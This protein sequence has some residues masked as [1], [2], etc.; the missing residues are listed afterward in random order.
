MRNRIKKILKEE[1]EWDWARESEP[2]SKSEI[3]NKLLRFGDFGFSIY[4]VETNDLVNSIYNLGL[5]TTQLD[6][7][8]KSLYGFGYNIYERGMDA[9]GE[10]AWSEG[11]R[12]G[13][14]EGWSEAKIECENDADYKYDKGHE[15]GYDKGYEEGESEGYVEGYK[16]GY[17]EGSEE[18]YYKAFEE[19]R[20]YEAGV[21]VEDLERIESGFDPRDYDEEYDENY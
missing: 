20:A 9:G 19:G 12:E 17:E 14:D 7:L 21:E 1:N 10:S 16:K 15:E 3:G 8:I 18:T 2:I 6:S 13:Y 4:N 5:N 11:H